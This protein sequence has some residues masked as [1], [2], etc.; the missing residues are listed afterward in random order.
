MWMM[1]AVS[2]C[3]RL[4]C[5]HQLHRCPTN[6]YIRVYAW[7]QSLQQDSLGV[8]SVMHNHLYAL[9]STNTHICT[10]A[11]TNDRTC[12]DV[13]SSCPILSSCV[14]MTHIQMH[15]RTNPPKG[16]LR[17]VRF[18]T[19]SG[20]CALSKPIRISSLLH[21]LFNSGTNNNNNNISFWCVYWV[22]WCE[23]K[24]RSYP[25]HIVNVMVMM[26]MKTEEKRIHI[27]VIC[28]VSVTHLVHT[29]WYIYLK[30]FFKNK[31]A[32]PR[33]TSSYIFY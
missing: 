4:W 31:V 33:R 32:V 28:V 10:C 12:V 15:I 24:S 27:Y 17:F 1:W 13:G 26:L 8:L 14:N 5:K 23:S 3:I 18:P 2:S 30:T 6:P 16:V 7:M 20:M 29:F 22:R 9:R 11:H 19:N 21:Q 25:K